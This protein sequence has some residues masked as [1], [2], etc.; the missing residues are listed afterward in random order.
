MWNDLDNARHFTEIDGSRM[1]FLDMGTGPAVLLGHSYLWAADMWHDQMLALS[2]RCRVIAP[3]LW[4]HGQSAALPAQTTSL[5]DL[6]AQNLALMDRLGIDEFAIVGMSVG[7]MWGAELAL[8]QPRRVVALAL[9]GTFAGS[10]PPA[11]KA[12][13]FSLIDTVAALGAVPDGVID[14]M[15]PL[16]FGDESL[17]ARTAVTDLFRTRLRQVDR[18]AL[19]KSILPLGKMTFGRRDALPDLK[20]L[21]IPSLVVTG[22][23][24]RSRPVHEGRLMAEVLGAK[25]VALPAT[26][27]ISPVE[28]PV[29][30]TRLLDQFL[31]H[32]F[33]PARS[34]AS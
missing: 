18:D 31:Q 13:Y 25:F 23:Q 16:F 9:L 30:V 11:S 17:A 21:P 10:E 3:D 24:D 27:H 7:G 4:G 14:I 6:A 8:M 1:S 5:R 34:K 15:L 22:A 29:E 19:N 33:N 32:V 26:G 20:D 28:S 12:Q 2:Q